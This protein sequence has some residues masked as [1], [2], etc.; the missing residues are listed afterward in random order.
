M[1]DPLGELS[2]CTYVNEW[3][4]EVMYTILRALAVRES[5]SIIRQKQFK[6]GRDGL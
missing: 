1:V 2:L 5:N 4:R 3:V 6:W